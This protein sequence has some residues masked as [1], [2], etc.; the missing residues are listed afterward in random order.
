MCVFGGV[1]FVHCFDLNVECTSIQ[2]LCF[3][4]PTHLIVEFCDTHIMRARRCYIHGPFHSKAA[5]THGWMHLHP[6]PFTSVIYDPT[7]PRVLLS[8]GNPFGP[9][10]AKDISDSL[11]H[12]TSLRTLFIA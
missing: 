4:V 1:A 6:S 10:A 9:D 12:L 8:R 11:V 3:F 2:T 7:L 5:G